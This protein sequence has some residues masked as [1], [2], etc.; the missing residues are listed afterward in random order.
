MHTQQRVW[1]ENAGDMN[2]TLTDIRA[3]LLEIEVAAEPAGYCL[4]WPDA[5]NPV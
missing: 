1:G 4:I 2:P 3:E 5:D